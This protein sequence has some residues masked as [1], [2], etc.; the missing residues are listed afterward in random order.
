MKIS[1]D[2]IDSFV[3]RSDGFF[4]RSKITTPSRYI[5]YVLVDE[6]ESCGDPYF[7]DI[8]KLNVGKGCFCSLS[9]F[10]SKQVDLRPDNK[11]W[12][13]QNHHRYSVYHYKLEPYG[14]LCRCKDDDILEV[15][16]FYC[17]RWFVPHG[18]EVRSK[19][20]S[21]TNGIGECNIYCSNECK[22]SCPTYKQS[23]Y[24]KG[25]K[26]NT[27]RE[28]QPQ[29]RKLVFERDKWK[30]QKCG[31]SNGLH[32][33]HITGVE[34]NPLESADIDNCMTLCKECHMMVHQQKGCTRNDYKKCP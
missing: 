10:N 24:P 1:W 33:H 12:V 25:F 13:K 21:I 15:K 20:G 31:I 6:C 23:L 18:N 32:C 11:R 30:C 16:C 29:L 4:N 8:R 28:V 22:I 26:P 34:I 14:V 3:I 7:T 17:D 5:K 27:S 2:N 9:C 19:V